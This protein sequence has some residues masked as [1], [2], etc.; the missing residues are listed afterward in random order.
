MD[1]RQC[2]IVDLEQHGDKRMFITEQVS[3]IN[4]NTKEQW[5]VRF[6]S[7]PRPFNYNPHR[8]LYLTD[9]VSICLDD[10]GLYVRNKHITGVAELFRF[11][12]S[13]YTF[14]HVI[15]TDG[16]HENLCDNDVYRDRRNTK[17]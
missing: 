16:Y 13:R 10:K 12:N 14:Y 5:T 17:N 4:M 11:A 15:H 2:M 8:L 6:K 1:A 3:S 7:S 9:P